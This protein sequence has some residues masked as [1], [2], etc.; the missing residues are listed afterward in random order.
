MMNTANITVS[1]AAVAFVTVAMIFTMFASPVRAQSVDDLQTQITALM[2]QIAALSGQGGTSGSVASGVCPFTWTRDLSQGASGD[3]VM[4][5]QQFLN[6]NADTRVAATGAGSV[7]AE[8][9]FFGPAT[10]AAVSKF[11]MMHMAEILTPAGLMSGTGYFGP[12][13]RAKANALCTTAPVTT[14]GTGTGTTTAPTA[15]TALEGGEGSLEVD[16]VVD[17]DVTIDLGSAEEVLT[18]EVTAEDSDVAINRVDYIFDAR[19]WLYFSEVNLLVDGEEVASLTRS[20]DFTEVGTDYRAR[21]GGLELVLREDDS[22]EV[23]LELVALASMAGT[24]DSDTVEVS[25]TLDM[26]RFTDAAGITDE[27]GVV[28][29]VDVDFDD[30]FGEGDIK[31]TEASNSP[32]A[33]TIVL[34]DS[35][36][37]NDV[38]VLVFE[39]EAEDSD[40]EV[41]DVR[42]GLTLSANTLATVV[43]R[44]RLLADG[45][46]VATE[47]AS[48]LGITGDI[49]F[50]DIEFMI[51][52]DDTVEFS[53]EVD[54]SRG[55]TF[56]GSLPLTFTVDDIRVDGETNDFGIVNSGIVTVDEDHTLIVDGIVTKVSGTPTA[57]T[58][59]ADPIASSTGQYRVRVDVTAVGETVFIPETATRGTWSNQGIQ[60]SIVN[61]AGTVVPTDGIAT[62]SFTRVTGGSLSGGFVRINDGQTATFELYVTYDPATAGQFRVQANA[63]GTNTVAAAAVTANN[64]TPTENFR[65]PLTNVQ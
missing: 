13:T 63:I 65:T 54:F 51:D 23:T 27:D 42:V 18:V 35:S 20:S 38:E 57:S 45:Q 50:E 3:D 16:T 28:T 34:E 4:K 53:V 37:T 47:G 33:A 22:V 6:A 5:L 17:A 46:V 1:K 32:E 21:F 9:M 41:S 8:T 59:T 64:L 25:T 10:A 2:A 56:A 24:R 31:V 11:Q 39:V 61:D 14:P 12:S 40:I 15:P 44:A 52:E 7:G 48:G 55:D 58:Q 29:A 62:Q 26:A 19:P 49:L 43:N 30:T 36:R 60:Y